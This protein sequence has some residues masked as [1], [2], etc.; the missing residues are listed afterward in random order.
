MVYTVIPAGEG[1]TVLLDK[2]NE[3]LSELKD[4]FQGIYLIL[5]IFTRL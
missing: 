1:R 3:L 4:I 5:D 2:V